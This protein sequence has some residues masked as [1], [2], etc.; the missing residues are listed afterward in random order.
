MIKED[1]TQDWMVHTPEGVVTVQAYYSKM[2]QRQ[3]D[4]YQAAG[5]PAD[6]YAQGDYYCPEL[7][8]Y[9]SLAAYCRA[10]GRAY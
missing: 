3:R 10:T 8:A 1:G 9:P 6:A 5:I 7:P 4:L 2:S